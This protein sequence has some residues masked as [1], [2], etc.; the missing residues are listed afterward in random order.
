MKSRKITLL[1]AFSLLLISLPMISMDTPGTVKAAKKVARWAKKLGDMLTGEQ[2]IGNM[3]AQLVI[4][5]DPFPFEKLPNDVKK[6]IILTASM[7]NAT[8]SLEEAA[9]MINNLTLVNKSLNNLINDPEFCLHLIK[10][11]AKRFDCS[12]FDVSAILKTK[13]AKK[14][15]ALQVDLLDLCLDK[16][17]LNENSVEVH[18]IALFRNSINLNYT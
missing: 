3:Q 6:E 15:H 9:Q 12:D 5:N 4:P 8:Q 2:P 11:L 18:L 10:S 7:Y 13:Q 14:Q 1:S 16:Y 17:K